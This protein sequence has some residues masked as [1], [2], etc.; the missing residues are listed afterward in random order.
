LASP[1]LDFVV[2]AR[3]SPG[4]RCDHVARFLGMRGKRRRDRP[5]SGEF[6][7]GYRG[8]GGGDRDPLAV[9]LRERMQACAEYPLGSGPRV[10]SRTSSRR[11]AGGRQARDLKQTSAGA[12]TRP[13]PTSVASR[14]RAGCVSI[15]LQTVRPPR[16]RVRAREGQPPDRLGEPKVAWGRPYRCL[17]GAHGKRLATLGTGG[18]AVMRTYLAPE[19]RR[20]GPHV[21][22]A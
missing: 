19:L 7:C 11:V 14:R 10:P 20:Y 18:C 9:P 5:L 8:D 3:L 17:S 2:T 21:T 15:P 13:V 12:D 6:L 16:R 22:R 4:Q 1:C